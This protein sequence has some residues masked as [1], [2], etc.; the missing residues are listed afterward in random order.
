MESYEVKDEQVYDVIERLAKI[1]GQMHTVHAHIDNMDSTHIPSGIMNAY[2]SA[3]DVLRSEANHLYEDVSGYLVDTQR[4]NRRKVLLAE[5]DAYN[6]EFGAIVNA[7]EQATVEVT[8]VSHAL[9]LLEDDEVENTVFID[10]MN[11]ALQESSAE[12]TE[13]VEPDEPSHTVDAVDDY[14]QGEDL[15]IAEILQAQAD[16]DKAAEDER[17][18]Q[19]AEKEAEE[20][21]QRET[22]P[23]SAGLSRNRY[24]AL[25][26]ESKEA[27]TIMPTDTL[28]ATHMYSENETED[29]VHS[30]EPEEPEESAA[31][32]EVSDEDDEDVIAMSADERVDFSKP[33]GEDDAEIVEVE[34]EAEVVEDTEAFAFEDD[35]TPSYL[36]GVEA[37]SLID[38]GVEPTPI[39]PAVSEELVTPTPTPEPRETYDGTVVVST[40]AESLAYD[41]MDEMNRHD[42]ILQ[43]MDAEEEAQIVQ[44]TLETIDEAEYHEGMGDGASPVGDDENYMQRKV[45]DSEDAL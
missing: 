29:L 25:S 13:E 10:A 4:D 36:A 16:A 43:E 21:R 9:P 22:M 38:V 35:E 12:V 44:E 11:D 28:S 39:E 24:R 17:L 45:N 8:P 18:A 37:P 3:F 7:S 27:D 15:M 32:V 19:E 41:E 31:D 26:E 33:Y 30:T 2:Y 1:I 23:T 34:E 40:G 14:A 42:A 20:Q 5:V 6:K